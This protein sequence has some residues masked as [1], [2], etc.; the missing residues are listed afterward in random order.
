MKTTLSLLIALIFGFSFNSTAG[1]FHFPDEDYAYAKLY[2]FNLGEIRTMPDFDIYTEETGWAASAVDPDIYSEHGLAENMTKLFLYGADGL[3]TGLSK[4][5]IPRHG[6]VYFDENDN[7]V[8]SLSI[9][10]ECEGISMWTKSKGKIYAKT[11][12][13]ESRAQQQIKTLRKFILKEGVI[14]SDEPSDYNS[15]NSQAEVSVTIERD[16]LNARIIKATY[17]DVWRWNSVNTF[18]EYTNVEYSA[19]GEKYEFIEL[20]VED[21][22][23][24]YFDGPDTDAKLVEAEIQYEYITLPN[25]IH[26]GSTLDDV[27]D[28]IGVYDGPSEPSEIIFKSGYQ[29]IHYHLIDKKVWKININC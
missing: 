12:G 19:G 26:V 14:V 9:C 28:L 20:H 18:S 10:F 29:T 15:I 11:D 5:F 25:G 21:H 23:H 27:M 22:A 2:Y 6:L 3:L 8:A 1:G 24:F 17:S 16:H 13:L 7:P 4:C